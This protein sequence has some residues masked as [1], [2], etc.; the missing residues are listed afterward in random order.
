[1]HGRPLVFVLLLLQEQAQ[2]LGSRGRG[3]RERAGRGVREGRSGK[4]LGLGAEQDVLALLLQGG[5]VHLSAGESG[6]VVGQAAVHEPASAA[7]LAVAA[8]VVQAG[9]PAESVC[10]AK[11]ELADR[12][13]PAVPWAAAVGP[14]E[15]TVRE[16]PG[17]VA[18]PGAPALAGGVEQG[19]LVAGS[20]IVEERELLLQLEF[21]EERVAGGKERRRRRVAAGGRAHKVVPDGGGQGFLRHR[22]IADDAVAPGEHGR[23]RPRRG[24]RHRE[25]RRRGAG[26]G[27]ASAGVL[28]GEQERRVSSGGGRPR[29]GAGGRWRE[30]AE[31][32]ARLGHDGVEQR[33]GA[34]GE[35]Y[36]LLLAVVLDEEEAHDLG[37]V[38]RVQRLD[39]R[40]HHLGGLVGVHGWQQASTHQQRASCSSSWTSVVAGSYRECVLV[41]EEE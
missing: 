14:A 3:A 13:A 6:G 27:A 8:C 1:M 39:P 7:V 20:S 36:H 18:S 32:L 5:G 16:E 9:L 26:A 31:V 23:R 40:E 22:A 12:G 29:A 41:L 11:T 17:G 28:A 21:V 2:A 35:A 33:L 37:G 19:K 34:E 4:A 25:R 10:T 15:A 24:R 38:V 30:Q